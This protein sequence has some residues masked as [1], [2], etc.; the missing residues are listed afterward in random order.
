MTQTVEFPVP[1]FPCEVTLVLTDA[2][3]RA[4]NSKA[5]VK[6]FGPYPHRYA[7]LHTWAGDQHFGLFYV[8]S[9]VSVELIAHEVFHASL[10]MSERCHFALGPDNHEPTAFLHGWLFN[11]VFTRLRAWGCKL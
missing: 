4:R 3:V 9:E 11:E 2:P 6:R 8:R 5:M 10:R 1:I 7:G